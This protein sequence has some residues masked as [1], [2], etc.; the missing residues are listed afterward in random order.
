M[1]QSIRINYPIIGGEAEGIL[2]FASQES[3]SKPGLIMVPNW[4]GVTEDAISLAEKAAEQGYVV[5]IADLYGKQNRPKNADE[6]AECMAKVKNTPAETDNIYRAM[7]ALSN[8]SHAAVLAD[9]ISDYGFC[10]GGHNV[11]EFERI[12]ED[13]S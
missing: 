2:V 4:M 8:Q 3:K 9:N 11:L 10:I 6:A 5:L 1:F 12:G 13:V 7:E